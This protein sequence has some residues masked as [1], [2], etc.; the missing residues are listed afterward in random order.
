MHTGVDAGF[1]MFHSLEVTP[2][3]VHDLNV[4]HALLYD[5][6]THVYGGSGCRDI[7]KRAEH[8]H[9][10]IDW[11]IA[12]RPGGQNTPTGT[13]GNRARAERIKASAR[14]KV[15]HP[16][17]T[18]K[19]QFGYSM[20]RYRGLAKNANRLY[21]LAALSNLLIGERYLPA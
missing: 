16:F 5:D 10:D 1:G 12:R 21:L 3:N 4:S 17:R 18:I 11:F 8:R 15:E 14:A 9:R 6:E 7:H 2:A 13:V 19:R 20:V